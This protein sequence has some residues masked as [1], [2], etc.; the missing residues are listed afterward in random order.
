MRQETEPDYYTVSITINLEAS[1]FEEAAARFK[2]RLAMMKRWSVLVEHGLTLE[3]T[4]VE[5]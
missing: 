5:V 1:S 4:Y 3:Q 2:R